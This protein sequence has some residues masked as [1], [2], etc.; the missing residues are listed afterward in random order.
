MIPGASSC[1]QL[2]TFSSSFM[3]DNDQIGLYLRGTRV[4]Q[5]PILLL[6]QLF[7]TCDRWFGSFLDP[8]LGLRAQIVHDRLT[9]FVRIDTNH[10]SPDHL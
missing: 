6:Q 2:L 9:I 7:L 5:G 4:G 1:D 3:T 10:L 8:I